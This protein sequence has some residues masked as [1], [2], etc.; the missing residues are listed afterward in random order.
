MIDISSSIPGSGWFKI[1][2]LLIGGFPIFVRADAVNVSSDNIKSK[3]SWV[4]VQFSVFMDKF[5][6]P[7]SQNVKGLSIGFL[8]YPTSVMGIEMGVL[9]AGVQDEAW[10]IQISPNA[11]GSE[12][13]SNG[14]VI[15]CISFAATM[16][17][18]E[19]GGIANFNSTPKG[20][21]VLHGIQIAGIMNAVDSAKGGQLGAL[22]YSGKVSG[23]Q[24]GLINAAL[25]MQGLQVG[26]LN[27]S[28]RNPMEPVQ[29]SGVQVGGMNYICGKVTG[30]QIGLLNYC[31][32]LH[33]VQLGLLNNI[34]RPGIGLRRFVPILNFAWD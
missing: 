28:G 27:T 34:D 12:H 19:I 7:P 25:E 26:G 33:G 13:T 8:P 15:S 22:N 14:L 31:Q 11:A 23:V 17:G 10:G 2:F 18:I 16:N 5:P 30:M 6:I 3:P 32:A 21:S 4:P 29:F 20:S 1:L 9:G 24:L